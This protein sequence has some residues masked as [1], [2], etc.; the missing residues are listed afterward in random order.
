MTAVTKYRKLESRGLWRDLPE[1]QRREVVVNLG[2]Q[3]LILTDPRSDT[4][5]SHWSLPAV[6]RSNPGELPALY[7][8]GEEATETLEIDDSDMI[9]A[10]ETVHA[11]IL[12]AQPRPGRLRGVM[13]VSALAAIAAV[14]LFWLPDALVRHTA[15]VLPPATRA[16]IGRLELADLTRI[17]GAPCTAAPGLAALDRMASRLFGPKDTPHLVVLREGVTGAV[18]LPGNQIVLPEALLVV[19]D[20]P[21]VAAGH[22]LAARLRAEAGDPVL[23]LLRY[24]GPIATLRLLT[25]GALPPGALTGYAETLLQ[26]APAPVPDEALL[27]AFSAAQVPATPYAYALDQ[28]GESTLGLIEADPLSGTS[29]SPLLPDADWVSLQDICTL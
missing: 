17:A 15:S 29:A 1:G 5:L 2:D 20:G 10:L 9:A 3:T 6:I 24:A 19:P 4:P 16:E 28:T 18:A 11:A 7:L 14:F 22:V 21:E 8:P 12:R 23:A 27:A 26:A 25:T 13:L